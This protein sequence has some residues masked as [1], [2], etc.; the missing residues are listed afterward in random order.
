MSPLLQFISFVA[1]MEEK[2]VP[3]RFPGCQCACLLLPGVF[4]LL[5]LQFDAHHSE[6]VVGSVVVDV[7]AA[8]A[9]LAGLDGH[10]LLTGVVVDHHRGPRLADTLLTER[11][12]RGGKSVQNQSSFTVIIYRQN[13]IRKSKKQRSVL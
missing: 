1:S 4:Y 8:E 10:P 12:R 9:L 13:T 2:N 6:G 11:G 5:V 3:F 7:D